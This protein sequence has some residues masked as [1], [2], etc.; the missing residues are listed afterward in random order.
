MPLLSRRRV[1][2]AKVESVEGTMEAITV[3]EA[4]ILALDPKFDATFGVNERS[5]MLNTLSKLQPVMGSRS[6]KLTFKAELK[7]AG[8]AYSASVKPAIG[9]YLRACGMLETIDVTASNEK[10]TYTPASSG[11]PSLTIWLY[12]DGVVKKMRGARGT[13][14]ITGEVGGIIMA[15]F[16]FTGVFDSVADLGMISPTFE[17]TIPPVLQA[18]TFSCDSYAA[19]IKSISLDCANTVQLRESVSS[20]DGY[21]SALITDRKPTGKFDPEFTTVAVYD[22]FTKWKTGSAGALTLGPIAPSTGNYNKFTI[23]APKLVYTGLGEGSRAGIMTL[24]TAFALAMNTGDD[25][26]QIQFSK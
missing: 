15:E 2:A 22:W 9:M 21:V 4:G 13:F 14:S 20:A 26:F 16:T 3:S 24:D 12:E 25:E 1:I 11:V 10:A 8:A 19:V 17:A 7:G 6:A 23:T 5:N 18:A